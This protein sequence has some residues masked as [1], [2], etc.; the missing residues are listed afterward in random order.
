[1]AAKTRILVAG[2]TGW[3]G[4]QIADALLRAGNAEVR[5][6]VRAGGADPEKE[7]NLNELR[8]RGLSVAFG[9]LGDPASLEAVCSG[10][11]VVISAVQG[12][13]DVIIDGQRNLLGAAEVAGVKRMIPS[14][15]SVDISRLDYED[16]YNL[17]LRKKFGEVLS[18]SRVASTPVYCGG[19]LDV[20]LSPRFPFIDWNKG[21][22]RYW[23][24]GN[25][26]IDYT[27]I[28]DVALFTAAAATDPGM[29]GRP[30]RVAGSSLTMREMQRALEAASGRSLE[31]QSLGTVDELRA[32]I[33]EKKRTAKNPWEWISLQYTWCGVSGKGKL[34]ALDNSRYPR[35]KPLTVEVRPANT[36]ARSTRRM[37]RTRFSESMLP[38]S[39]PFSKSPFDWAMELVT[40]AIQ[41]T[42]R[43][44]AWANAYRADASIS[45]QS[46]PSFRARRMAE[47][48]SRNGAS[49]VQEVPRPRGSGESPRAALRGAIILAS[50]RLAL[51]RAR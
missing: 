45:T 6:L 27:A 1:M 28:S 41:T 2:V 36:C 50:Q 34:Q 15:F 43:C 46:A 39:A 11:E 40:W 32:L 31:A 26:P 12:G 49:V 19:F 48:V 16:N 5:G 25:Q 8:S 4:R 20:L 37:K 17:G 30:L 18:A 29:T 13:P 14:D 38:P 33:E 42:S 24:D 23:G 3:L 22:M 21:L 47:A 51:P 35:I 9:N 10:A 44:L 7:K